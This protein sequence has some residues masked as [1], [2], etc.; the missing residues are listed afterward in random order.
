MFFGGNLAICVWKCSWCGQGMLFLF[1]FHSY[2][3]LEKCCCCFFKQVDQT[4]WMAEFDC[5]MM[6]YQNLYCFVFFWDQ[7]LFF[8]KILCMFV[9]LVSFT[10][11]FFV[12]HHVTLTTTHSI[13]LIIFFFIQT[14]LTNVNIHLLFITLSVHKTELGKGV[15]FFET[16]SY[17]QQWGNISFT[18]WFPLKNVFIFYITRHDCHYNWPQPSWP[19]LL[20]HVGKG[21]KCLSC[22]NWNVCVPFTVMF[23]V[24]VFSLVK[25]TI[26]I[27]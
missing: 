8:L 1:S 14:D 17:S 25:Y 19:P 11:R 26:Q 27:T 6:L 18:S 24:F 9:N 15:E 7:L 23:M 12:R 22:W 20:L 21:N 10:F 13:L 3:F 4:L 2:F 16:S 5:D